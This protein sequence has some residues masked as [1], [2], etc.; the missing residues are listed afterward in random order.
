MYNYY[1]RK[2]LNIQAASD[3]ANSEIASDAT[4][5]LLCEVIEATKSGQLEDAR[6]LLSEA[7]VLSGISLEYTQKFI[8]DVLEGTV[9]DQTELN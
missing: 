4:Y 7:S 9:D 8:D 5:D 1:M 3:F 6:E 2:I